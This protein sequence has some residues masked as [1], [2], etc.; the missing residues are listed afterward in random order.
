[1]RLALTEPPRGMERE[2]RR[3]IRRVEGNAGLLLK[4]SNQFPISLP[5]V[6]RVGRG[7]TLAVQGD[8]EDSL[9]ASCQVDF[10]FTQYIVV[11]LCTFLRT[12]RI[13]EFPFLSAGT[14][15]LSSPLRNE[16]P[17]LLISALQSVTRPLLAPHAHVHIYQMIWAREDGSVLGRPRLF[18]TTHTLCKERGRLLCQRRH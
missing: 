7:P 18:A 14:L 9:W 6:S 16:R 17:P 8:A 1:M 10:Y 2:K 5:G 4:G 11:Y 3:I 13:Q 12:D 15:C